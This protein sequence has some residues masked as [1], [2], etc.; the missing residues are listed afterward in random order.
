MDPGA[1][2][3]NARR[4][5]RRGRQVGSGAERQRYRAA[6]IDRRQRAVRRSECGTPPNEGGTAEGTT[7][8]PERRKVVFDSWAEPRATHDR[9]IRSASP[10]PSASPAP[11][12]RSCC[13]RRAPPTSRRRSARSCASTTASRPPTCSSPSRAASGWAATASWASGRGGCSRSATASPRTTTRPVGVDAYAPDL[14]VDDDRGAGPARGA[15]RVR[16]E[17]P[18]R[19]RPRAC[20]ASPAARSARSP[21]T[22]SARSSRRSRC[23]TGPRRRPARGASSRRTSSSC[24]TT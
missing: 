14:P 7:F 6:P 24:S 22:R 21:T 15:A 23:P 5:R 4:R 11:P 10:K 19:C 3:P 12:T 9:P 18:G 16:P 8:R 1:S 2:G 13:A 17:A 20:R